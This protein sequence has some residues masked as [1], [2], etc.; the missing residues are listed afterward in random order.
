MLTQRGGG[1]PL[2]MFLTPDGRCRSSAA[3]TF[4]RRRATACRAFRSCCQ[5]VAAATT[6][7]TGDEIA[8]AERGA[9]GAL[10]AHRARTAARPA[11]R[12][13]AR[14]S[15]RRSERSS[16][17]STPGTAASAAR[18][19]FRTRPSSSSALR[20][21][22]RDRRRAGAARSRR[23]RSTRMAEG[24]IYDQ[25]GGGFCR[26]SVDAT[27][28]HPALREDA[29]RQRPAAARST[30]T[31][32]RGDRRSRSSSASSR[33]TAEWMMRE[34]Q[35]PE[36]GYYSSLDAD[37]ER[38]EG[39][40]Y[41]WTPGEVARAAD[42]RGVRRRRAALRPR[43]PAEFR[44]QALAPRA[45]PMPLAG[46]RRGARPRARTSAR[47]CSIRRAQKL[48]ARARA[49]RA[50]RPRR[51]DAR[52]LER[53]DDRAAWRA[54]RAVFGAPDWLDSA[55]RALDFHPRDDVAATAALLATYKDGRAHLN[56]YLDDHAFLLDALLELLQTDFRA[57]RSRVRARAR[58]ACC[59]TRFEDREAAASSSPATTTSG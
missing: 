49:A 51:E 14:R 18:R 23:S 21:H 9:R 55:R 7:S 44:G 58:R 4:R 54:P 30:P 22:A 32:W 41:V 12:S 38:E 19:S 39:K 52:E 20:R 34:M 6:A 43:R 17:A 37:S 29:L 33:E 26:Y 24:G 2:T 28:D 48:F 5:Q 16:R 35:S 40:F 3:R 8:R 13:P 15:R 56:A 42:A 57:C 47:R 59:S 50:A 1:W 46:R 53:A 36:G 45:S 10:A 31:R 27:L 11:T 25:L